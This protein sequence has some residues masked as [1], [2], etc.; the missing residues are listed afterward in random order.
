MLVLTH[1]NSQTAHEPPSL[2]FLKIS[3]PFLFSKINAGL[4]VL[5]VETKGVQCLIRVTILARKS[6]ERHGLYDL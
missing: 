3:F 1:L 2:L 6:C 4:A 5:V